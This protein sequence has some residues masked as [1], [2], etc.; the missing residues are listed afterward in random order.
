MD[1]FA[2][3]THDV[4]FEAPGWASDAAESL[5]RNGFV[6]LRGAPLQRD[7]CDRCASSARER[8]D[9]LL[10]LVRA[11]KLDTEK[12]ACMF[13]E[14]CKRMHQLRW[15]VRLP[16]PRAS[17]P[18]LPGRS[19]LPEADL[20]AW[21][22]LHAE[23]HRRA[24]P[25]L[26]EVLGITE[27]QAN[28]DIAG[29]VISQPGTSDQKFHQDG[30]REGFFNVFVPLVDVTAENGPTQFQPGSQ[31]PVPTGGFAFM[32]A[33][34]QHKA[35]HL[36]IGEVLI[37][38][39]RVRH[40]GLANS[41]ESD[42]PVAY[43][44][45]TLPGCTDIHNFPD[46]SLF[47]EDDVPTNAP[48][49]N[50][51][52]DWVL[53]ENLD[54][55]AGLASSSS[56]HDVAEDKLSW[57]HQLQFQKRAQE[58]LGVDGCSDDT[59][60]REI[61]GASFAAAKPVPLLEPRLVCTSSSGMALIGA[62]GPD[63]ASAWQLCGNALPEAAAPA[64]HCYCGY[65]YG[66]FSGQL[67]DGAALTLGELQLSS[68][69]SLELSLKGTG[70]NAV[71]RWWYTGLNG[72]KHLSMM[73]REF[74][75][76]EALFALGV[77]TTRAVAVVSGKDSAD[78]KNS[79]CAVLL[80]AAD[81]F[82]RFG[83][84]EVTLPHGSGHHAPSAFDWRL[85]RCLADHC[86]SECY[87]H[88]VGVEDPEEDDE[89]F[90]AAPRYHS[91]VLEVTRRTARLAASWQCLGAVHGMLNT[92]NMSIS[93]LTL[94][95]GSFA[96]LDHFD[97][98]FA[99]HAREPDSRYCYRNQPHAARWACERLAEALVPLH[100]TQ[101]ADMLRE[102][103]AAFDAEYSTA[104]DE[105]MRRK[106]GL[107]EKAPRLVEDLLSLMER[108]DADWTCTFQALTNASSQDEAAREL[109]RCCRAGA[110]DEWEAW[111]RQYT[112]MLAS[113]STSWQ[114]PGHAEGML[115]S[116]PV[117]VPREWIL[118]KAARAAETG[119]FA[120]VHR[121]L[122]ML[123]KPF[124]TPT[125]VA[126]ARPPSLARL[127]A[128]TAGEV[129]AKAAEIL[130]DADFWRRLC[131]ELRV[132]DAASEGACA[133]VFEV[134]EHQVEMLRAA[135]KRDGVFALPTADLP[136]QVDLAKLAW[137]V[138]ELRR[139]GWPPSFIWVYDEPWIM[140]AQLAP[141]L[142]DVLG[143][144]PCFDVAASRVPPGEAGIAFHRERPLAGLKTAGIT[145]EDVGFRAD[146]TPA[147]ASIWVPLV[148]VPQ[149]GSCLMCVPRANDAG[150]T[151]SGNLHWNAD[152]LQHVRCLSM[153][154]GGA[155]VMSHRLFHWSR[156]GDAVQAD[157]T[158]A[159]PCVA[160]SFAVAED[161]FE[162]P[163]L[164]RRMLPLPPPQLRVALAAGQALTRETAGSFST[165][166]GQLFWDCFLQCSEHFDHAYSSS[167]Y[168]ARPQ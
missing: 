140:L 135:M 57:W 119:D 89:D 96:F 67:G 70:I 162:S 141:L 143:S 41:S 60:Y 35:P 114:H 142:R 31:A 125:N 28:I 7:L 146:G 105:G 56:A 157:G 64:A 11:R 49:D 99:R 113:E 167:V 77:P 19:A 153:G 16:A 75:V 118:D 86:I 1:P 109:C 139:A 48:D 8:L 59:E 9:T 111:L 82:L 39:Y 97:P 112:E 156:K 129:G 130:Q 150:Y 148:D 85:L 165:E 13:H 44:V 80:R 104:F 58:R 71:T 92:D 78:E 32:A 2:P 3:P 46:R 164:P 5:R 21:A 107:R 149:T 120:E 136:W 6:A 17:A 159:P 33:P 34:Q 79:S 137:S 94:D 91:F 116:N 51:E 126:E 110:E 144:Q 66:T 15:D 22:E 10:P 83:S 18:T 145:G 54:D 88:L 72:R 29:C 161:A 69:G 152:M 25:V 26:R 122:E 151:E 160:L 23:A 93:G 38:D 102:V 133:S 163:R 158:T 74:L 168:M 20:A 36:K 53:A 45:Y 63:A 103:T 27:E 14:L 127:D 62:P 121:I 95:H 100:C 87:Q 12:D 132:A 138:E 55:L 50:T 30:S 43:L 4:Q 124:E 128:N 154:A 76:A 68:G 81:T 90:R 115:A 24:W 101:I 117:V 47:Q 40:R 155:G 106:L 37:F 42:R 166:M 65:Q 147:F 134:S 98:N 131:P 73:V 61:R 108:T 52:L 84:F 123:T